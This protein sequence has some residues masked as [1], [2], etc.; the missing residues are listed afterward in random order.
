VLTS[1]ALF[2]SLPYFVISLG[3][4]FRYVYPSILLTIIVLFVFCSEL[5]AGG[6]LS[7]RKIASS[8]L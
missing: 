4:D 7:M 6:M 1:S 5:G 2:Y 8:E 3:C